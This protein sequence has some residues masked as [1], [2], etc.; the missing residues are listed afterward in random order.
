VH[1]HGHPHDARLI[2]D[3]RALWIALVLILALLGGELAAGLVAGSL[4]LLADA[5]HMLTDAGALGFA[6]FAA[7]LAGRPP[8]GR[9]TFGFRRVEV[10]AAQVN[11]VTLG[12]AAL[13]IVYSAARRLASPPDVDA[14]LVL[15]VA[16]A[17]AAVNLVATG[18]L[19]RASHRSLNVRGAYVHLATDLAAF[20]G[21]AV[22]AGL[23][24]V[25]GWDRF[26]PLAGLG[27]AALM[28]WASF[29]LLRESGR[30]FLEMSPAE[31]DPGEVGRAI[32]RMPH[33]VETHDLH[34]WTV[35]SGFPA[36]SA[37][38]LVEPGADCHAVRREVDAMLKER[39]AVDHTTLQVDHAP[40]AAGPIDVPLRSNLRGRG[41]ARG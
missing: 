41:R 16:L 31:I 30:I 34:V 12:L 19:A 37:H 4:A 3:R 18:I 7:A 25:T 29:G 39:F 22:A 33:V 27:V 38:V 36:L 10:L 21:T 15:A 35:T 26:D 2:S 13:W 5:G 20:A 24:I 9:W 28:L 17:G 11:G 8:S 40:A 1:A 23:I 6:L 32:V 14:W